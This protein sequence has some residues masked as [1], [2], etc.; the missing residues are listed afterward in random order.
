MP[1]WLSSIARSFL[2]AP[3]GSPLDFRVT[4][5]T[6]SGFTVEWDP[7]N[8]L[9]RHGSINKYEIFVKQ[10]MIDV[11][12][13]PITYNYS[14]GNNRVA[15]VGGSNNSTSVCLGPKNKTNLRPATDYEMRIRAFN[16]NGPGPYSGVVVSR[17][18]ESGKCEWNQCFWFFKEFLFSSSG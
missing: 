18:L 5:R 10:R 11:H 14:I 4:D 15:T 2:L 13:T 16:S 17:T 12:L 9:L 8:S 6:C 3:K 1:L 7:V